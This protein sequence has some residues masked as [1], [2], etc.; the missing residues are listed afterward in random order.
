M[1][2]VAQ[3]R[4]YKAK[5]VTRGETAQAKALPFPDL[6][7]VFK[8]GMVLLLATLLVGC[9]GQSSGGQGPR[10]DG[11]T[12]RGSAKPVQGD[13]AE[14]VATA[15]QPSKS[16]TGATQAAAYQGKQ[17]CINTFGTSD[18][19]WIVGPDTPTSQLPVSESSL[20]LTGRC[21]DR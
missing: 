2:N 1:K 16:I 13:R 14:F 6:S 3:L 9:G 8:I 21:R 19:D 20:T 18:I 15:R 11:Q 5:P 10:F 17:Y 4:G 12:F 7:L